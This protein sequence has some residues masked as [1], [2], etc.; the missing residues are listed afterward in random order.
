MDNL[1]EINSEKDK[2]L[3]EL[4]ENEQLIKI[5][6]D[7]HDMKKETE[8][9]KVNKMQEEWKNLLKIAQTVEKDISGPVK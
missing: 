7:K 1:A 3:L 4:D 2:Y 8:L 5:L 6:A 9:K